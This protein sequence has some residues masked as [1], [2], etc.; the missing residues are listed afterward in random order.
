MILE[1]D[2]DL[3]LFV[4]DRL[5]DNGTPEQISSP[6]RRCF[7]IGL[8]IISRATIYAFIHRGDQ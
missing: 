1:R 4:L 7:E 5:A 2:H 8:R 3:K 6:L